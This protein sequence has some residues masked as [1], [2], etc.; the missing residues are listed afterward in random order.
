MAK[1]RKI[2]TRIWTDSKFRDLSDDGKFV[3]FALLTHPN[4]TSVGAMRGTLGGLAE[5][6][7]WLPER[8]RKGFQE[9]SSKGMV[10]HDGRAHLI[11]LPR[12]IRY[13]SPESPNVI[14][15][16]GQAYEQLPE[17]PLKDELFHMIKEYTE[18]YTE[19]FRKAFAEAFRQPCPNPEPEPEPEQEQER[20]KEDISV[21][22]ISENSTG[23]FGL[24][25]TTLPERIKPQDSD[26]FE[27]FWMAYP[28]RVA[29]GNARKAFRI[30]V[31]NAVPSVI[32]AGAER[33]ARE[34]RGQDPKFTP[35]PASWLNAGRWA[36]D[37]Q[38]LPPT[39]GTNP[40]MRAIAKILEK[41]DDEE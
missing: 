23:Q 29:K 3:F 35:H 28:R 7:G 25:P 8:L 31:K 19:G 1:F 30:A 36:D 33:F 11:V 4:L 13:N 39:V 22:P 10:K 38:A 27:M 24:E 37:P 6:I 17:C 5:E 15:G 40:M 16:W 41:K 9:A 34:R 18:A 14:R 26:D 12:F 20:D 32:I 21:K 2:D